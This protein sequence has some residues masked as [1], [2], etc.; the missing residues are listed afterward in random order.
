MRET[1]AH[2]GSLYTC[3]CLVHFVEP[4]SD[5]LQKSVVDKEV[6]LTELDKLRPQ[7]PSLLTLLN[8]IR[9]KLRAMDPQ[10]ARVSTYKYVDSKATCR[11][12]EFILGFSIISLLNTLSVDIFQNCCLF[13]LD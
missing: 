5:M 3:V 9:Q 6:Y 8:H 1:G 4:D 13:N 11:I 12:N 2:T 7:A 10:D